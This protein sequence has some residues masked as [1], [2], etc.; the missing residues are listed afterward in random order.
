MSKIVHLVMEVDEAVVHIYTENVPPQ[1]LKEAKQGKGTPL[2]GTYFY[3][4]DGPHVPT[5][6]YHLHVYEKNNQ[7]FAINWDGTAHDQSHGVTIPGKV[8]D[9]IQTKFP[10]LKLPANRII[11]SFSPLA[12]GRVFK[13]AQAIGLTVEELI[14]VQKVLNEETGDSGP[15]VVEPPNATA[16]FVA[17][18]I[19]FVGQP[20]LFVTAEYREDGGLSVEAHLFW[21]NEQRHSPQSY[22]FGITPDT[23]RFIFD[24]E[25][26][27]DIAYAIDHALQWAHGV[28]ESVVM[29]AWKK[30]KYG[31]PLPQHPFVQRGVRELLQIWMHG[32]VTADLR[33]VRKITKLATIA[34]YLDPIL[35]IPSF[36]EK[37]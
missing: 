15:V 33:R 22:P 19:P 13:T 7:L 2:A 5:G 17:D 4:K 16:F 10:K 6:Q 24:G 31:W 37:G 8:F 26:I 21:S 25:R 18:R 29:E 1:L 12:V 14:E 3:R 27:F 35:K 23:T 30:G 20:F 28:V 32:I 11:E 34:A 36:G 9:A